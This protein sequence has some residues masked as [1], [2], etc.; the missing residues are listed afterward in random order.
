MTKTE[1][2]VELAAL[3]TKTK[4]KK[5][6]TKKQREAKNKRNAE[7]EARRD[8]HRDVQT[9]YD[10]PDQILTW[11]QWL[12]LNTLSVS[13]GKRLLKDGKAPP[14]VQLSTHRVGVRVADNREWQEARLRD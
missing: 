1:S 3:L 2:A 13:Q 12:R 5:K 6:L 11:L 9:N 4:T 7:R 8:V 10:N 14:L